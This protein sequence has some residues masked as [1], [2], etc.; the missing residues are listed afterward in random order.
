M[1][2]WRQLAAL[3]LGLTV[4]VSALALVYLEHESRSLFVQR[5][6]LQSAQDAYQVEWSR[7]Q[8]EQAWLADAS[9]IENIARERLQMQRP[10]QSDLILI[11]P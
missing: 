9:R 3:M 4:I 2:R 5:Q 7:L 6:R 10:A 8:L 11:D 1:K